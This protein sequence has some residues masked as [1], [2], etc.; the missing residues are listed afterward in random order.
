MKQMENS[1]LNSPP[2]SYVSTSYK[3]DILYLMPTYLLNMP[4]FL[5]YS[6]EIKKKPLPRDCFPSSIDEDGGCKL[7]VLQGITRQMAVLFLY[8]HFHEKSRF[9]S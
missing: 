4:D 7:V 6:E 1:N 5:R 8:V 3:S 9:S 2:D